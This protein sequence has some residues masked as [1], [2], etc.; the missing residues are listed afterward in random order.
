M[1]RYGISPEI[2]GKNPEINQENFLRRLEGYSYPDKFCS[3]SVGRAV[4]ALT[5]KARH[6]TPYSECP[7]AGNSSERA[8][9]FWTTIKQEKLLSIYRV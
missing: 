8:K 4:R 2:G 1:Q 9:L 7:Y 5:P 3:A 6:S